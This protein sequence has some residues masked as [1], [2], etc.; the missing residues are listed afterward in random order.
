MSEPKTFYYHFN[1]FDFWLFFNTVATYLCISCCLKYKYLIYWPH[2]HIF[3]FSIGISWLLWIYKHFCKHAL[4]VITDE[5][6]K[7]DYCN[8]LPWSDIESAE[9]RMIRMGFKKIKVIIIK[10]KP[11]IDYHYNFL[12]KHN[13]AFTAFSLPLYPVI[14]IDDAIELRRLIT[15]KVPY[16]ALLYKKTKQ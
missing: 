4:A 2:T 5:S 13:G 1:H 10:P 14:T 7:I 11:D 9:E 6:I 15:E 3:L 16:N 8:P 12:Q